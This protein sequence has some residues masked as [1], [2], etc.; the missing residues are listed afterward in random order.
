MQQLYGVAAGHACRGRAFL[1]YVCQQAVLLNTFG[2]NSAKV[3]L[4]VMNLCVHSRSHGLLGAKTN[5][6]TP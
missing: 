1:Q 3:Q 2:T 4:A 6:V 5:G